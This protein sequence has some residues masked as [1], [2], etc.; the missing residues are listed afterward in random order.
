MS[1]K[2]F[3]ELSREE[4]LSEYNKLVS[5]YEKIKEEGIKLDMSRG[6]PSPE[7]LDLSDG[8]LDILKN[9]EEIGRASCRERV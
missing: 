8:M 1:K 5:E 3:S 7:Q 4:L 6:K 2:P 9:K